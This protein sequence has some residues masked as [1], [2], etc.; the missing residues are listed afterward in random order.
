M[1]LKKFALPLAA[2]LIIAANT[3]VAAESWTVDQAQSTLGFE[4]QQGEGGVT[5]EF[6]SWNATIDF[7]VEAPEAAKISAEISPGSASTGNSQIDMT[8]PAKDWF[9][10]SGFPVAEFAA[11]GASLVE[12]N[13]YQADGTLTIKGVSH[14]VK[15]DFTLDIDGDT[16]TAKGT[17][18][19]NRL[20]YQLG[21]G[22]GTD[23]LGDVVTIT[24]DLT[25]TR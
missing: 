11:E 9:D 6:T 18:Q 25:A 8:L 23:T 1:T 13:T 7:D 16:A 21:A 2:G 4:V 20:D 15:L 10:A 5:G 3:S 19:L 14:P 17:A 22:V 12:G 24:L